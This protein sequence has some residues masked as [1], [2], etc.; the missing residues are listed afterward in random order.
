MAG[1]QHSKDAGASKSSNRKSILVHKEISVGHLKDSKKLRD[2]NATKIVKLLKSSG[3]KRCKAPTF[4]F[5]MNLVSL[6]S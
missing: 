1:K 6:L 3:N 4:C 5:W 2:R